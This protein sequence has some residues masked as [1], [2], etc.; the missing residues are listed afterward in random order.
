MRVLFL[1]A[2]ILLLQ[3]INGCQSPVS[4][5]EMEDLITAVNN[6][7]ITVFKKCAQN[8]FDFGKVDKK[9]ENISVIAR[10]AGNLT[11]S[12]WL[13]DEQYNLWEKANDPNDTEH[14]ISAI[15]F[16][17][18][19]IVEEFF[20]GNLQVNEVIY[21]GMNPTVYAIF[22]DAHEVLKVLLDNGADVNAVFDFRA[23]I[24]MASMF[25]QKD[26]LETL[27]L[28]GADVN[29][30]D[31]SYVTPLMFAAGDGNIEIIEILLKN[32]A[33]RS[34]KDINGETAEDWANRGGYDQA[35]LLVK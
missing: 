32:G 17:N 12:N 25:E 6:T 26:I 14:L 33:D 9:G 22:N 20:D 21:S 18:S 2:S 11:I 31:G 27:I 34:L 35:A 19:R 28:H 7:N 10:K 15:E 24:A 3:I 13:K 4:T 23:L 30:P 29:D 1:L 5:C 8:G 16:D